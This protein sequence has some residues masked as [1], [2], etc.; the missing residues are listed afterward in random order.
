MGPGGS[1]GPGRGMGNTGPGSNMG[2]GGNMG[3]PPMWENNNGMGG[4]S[5]GPIAVQGSMGQ[6]T[7]DNSVG[8]PP[9]KMGPPRMMGAPPIIGPPP[10]MLNGMQQY[11]RGRPM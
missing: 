7:I 1:I 4:G 6:N 9:P 10:A 8:P 3:S 2:P 11:P 5:L